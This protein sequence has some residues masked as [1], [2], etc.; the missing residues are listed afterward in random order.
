M[1]ET[2]LR[3]KTRKMNSKNIPISE[4]KNGINIM[5]SAYEN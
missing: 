2:K 3:K 5:K 4:I 1:K